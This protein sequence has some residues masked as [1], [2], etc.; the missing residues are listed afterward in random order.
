MWT[1]LND[2]DSFTSQIL[3]KVV[4]GNPASMEGKGW[5]IG[6]IEEQLLKKSS[7]RPLVD[8]RLTVY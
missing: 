8:F 1:V 3:C 5:K 2:Y 7:S 6:E 4:K